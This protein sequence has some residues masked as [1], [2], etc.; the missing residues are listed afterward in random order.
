MRGKNITSIA[1]TL[2]LLSV[3][4]Y[5]F[6]TTGNYTNSTIWVIASP[7]FLSL[8]PIFRQNAKQ[9][10]MEQGEYDKLKSIL[11]FT[12][13]SLFA[14]GILMFIYQITEDIF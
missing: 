8:H 4:G 10:E 2:I 1:A 12:R 9:L 14:L 5:L 13:F 11:N 3:A 7:L 6:F